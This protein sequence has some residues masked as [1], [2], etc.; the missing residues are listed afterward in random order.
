MAKQANTKRV[1]VV[2]WLADNGEIS[3]APAR[4]VLARSPAGAVRHCA[5]T[6][7]AA[8]PARPLQVAELMKAGVVLEIAGEAQAQSGGG[9]EES[10]GLEELAAGS[11]RNG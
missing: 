2:N 11:K 4:L 7:L 6:F 5:E 9:A 1:Y 10:L 8:S 3:Q